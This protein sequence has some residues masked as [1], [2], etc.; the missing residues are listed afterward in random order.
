MISIAGLDK[1]AVLAALYNASRQQGLGL[2]DPQGWVAMTRQQAQ[3]ILDEAA[4][5]CGRYRFDYLRGR[6][7]KVN[8]DGDELNPTLYDRDNGPG[9]AA[10][11]IAE[12]WS[13]SA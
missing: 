11:V 4:K 9:A 5:N 1:A 6:V 3:D 2:L 13:L 7:L 10:A 12:L 8:L